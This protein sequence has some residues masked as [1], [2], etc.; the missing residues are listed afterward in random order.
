M[1]VAA[2]AAAP[3]LLATLTIAATGCG[4]SLYCR[5]ASTGPLSAFGFGREPE[6]LATLRDMVPET[7]TATAATYPGTRATTVVTVTLE[8]DWDGGTASRFEES[9]GWDTTCLS[10]VSFPATATVRSADGLFDLPQSTR[11]GL[12]LTSSELEG[13]VHWPPDSMAFR[14][15]VDFGTQWVVPIDA[16]PEAY[17]RVVAGE[18]VEGARVALLYTLER[19]V[20]GWVSPISDLD[21]WIGMTE[22]AGRSDLEWRVGHDPE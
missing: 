4:D 22:V 15:T 18:P 9:P 13:D 10:D 6:N 3:A 5:E 17:P 19:G 12:N 1:R 21:D 11:A 20:F 7:Y 2:R 8:V 16:L 14:M